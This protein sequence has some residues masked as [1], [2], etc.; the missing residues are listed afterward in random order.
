VDPRE[1]PSE[2][3]AA[4]LLKAASTRL[5]DPDLE[6]DAP[7]LQPPGEVVNPE[8]AN[9]LSITSYS[10]LDAEVPRATDVANLRTR[11]L[12]VLE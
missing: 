8:A 3:N 12:S 6:S 10:L 11:L 1:P 4:E 7:H 5:D 2:S 9:Q